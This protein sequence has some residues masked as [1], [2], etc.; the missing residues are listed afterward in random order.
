MSLDH[1]KARLE[2]NPNTRFLV[3]DSHPLNAHGVSHA[4]FSNP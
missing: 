2:A 1:S 3:R 4:V